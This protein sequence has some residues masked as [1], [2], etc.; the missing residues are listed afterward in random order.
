MRKGAGFILLAVVSSVGLSASELECDGS[1]HVDQASYTWDLGGAFGWVLGFAFP[2]EGKGWL[3]T[4][5]GDREIYSE[6]EVRSKKERDFY[7]YESRMRSKTLET[8]MSYHAYSWGKRSRSERTR[9]DYDRLEAT[10]EKDSSRSGKGTKIEKIPNRSL[11][12]VLT[13]I[14]FLRQ[15]LN[16]IRGSIDSEI[17]SDGD[18]YP[19]RY[20]NLG[21]KRGKLDGK[22]VTLRGF[23]IAARPGDGDKWP[24]GVEIWM[25]IDP[26]AIPVEISIVQPYVSLDL[27]LESYESCSH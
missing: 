1:T 11:K 16:A 14:E 26:R 18:L 15:N 27:V 13:G 7:R 12:D 23:E 9:F 5:R 2:D 3:R 24:G 17:Y 20:R 6:L 25:T 22:S 8:R 19:I 10:I 21:T 4:E